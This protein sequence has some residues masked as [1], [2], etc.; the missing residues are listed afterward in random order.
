MTNLNEILAA[1]FIFIGV[2]FMIISTI[3]ILRFPDFYIRMS[4]I[5]KAATLGVGFIALGAGAYYNDLAVAG[6]SLAIILFI[7][8]TTPVAAHII[9]RA[10]AK[11]K[12]PFWPGTDLEEF[13]HY[14]KAHSFKKKKK[15]GKNK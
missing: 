4:A 14:L 15:K 8:I 3:G 10:A 7:L 6:K 2:F 5:S 1:I 12:V 13:K 11:D 9:A